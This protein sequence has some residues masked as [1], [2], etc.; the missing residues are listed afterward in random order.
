M[1]KKFIISTNG[2]EWKLGNSKRKK[3]ESVISLLERKMSR[4]LCLHQAKKIAVI[5]NYDKDTSN[6]TLN[7]YDLKYTLSATICFLED[8]LSEQSFRKLSNKYKLEDIVPAC[9]H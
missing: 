9:N 3:L 5:V 8:F 1:V 2:K 7:S 4:S 6:E